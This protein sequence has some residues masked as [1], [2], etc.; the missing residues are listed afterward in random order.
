LKI[1]WEVISNIDYWTGF[2]NWNIQ[3][4]FPFS[5]L[6]VDELEARK[7]FVFLRYRG[8]NSAS[9]QEIFSVGFDFARKQK[10]ESRRLIDSIWH[11]RRLSRDTVSRTRSMFSKISGGSH[12]FRRGLPYVV[13]ISRVL[14]Q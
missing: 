2:M 11:F 5:K 6:I 9:W 12:F 1:C 13:W 7:K 3:A 10:A 4:F 14:L 8:S